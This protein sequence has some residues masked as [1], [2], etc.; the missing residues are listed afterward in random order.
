MAAGEWNFYVEQGATWNKTITVRDSAGD[1]VDL[2]DCAVEMQVRST[3]QSS[4]VI[5]TPAVAVASA[6]EGEITLELMAAQT[7]ALPANGATF[8]DTSQYVYDLRIIRADN[9]VERVLNGNFEV[10]PGVTRT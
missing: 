6:L 5:V 10:S 3:P 4:I 1:P 9:T 7:A 2:T 8:R